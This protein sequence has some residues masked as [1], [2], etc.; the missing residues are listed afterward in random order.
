MAKDHNFRAHVKQ[1]LLHEWPRFFFIEFAIVTIVLLGQW[2]VRSGHPPKWM[3]DLD[4]FASLL[5]AIIIGGILHVLVGFG[6]ALASFVEKNFENY[7]KSMQNLKEELLVQRMMPTGLNNDSLNTLSNYLLNADKLYS[8][9]YVRPSL[10]LRLG[11][12]MNVFCLQAYYNRLRFDQGRQLAMVRFLVWEEEQFLSPA[13]IFVIRASLLVGARTKIITKTILAE[14]IKK[15][16]TSEQAK[17]VEC[18]LHAWLECKNIDGE[19]KPQSGRYG[20]VTEIGFSD[21][22]SM[23]KTSEAIESEANFFL[24]IQILEEFSMEVELYKAHMPDQIG[25]RNMKDNIFHA[26]SRLTSNRR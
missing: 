14:V 4:T 24:L 2:L 11:D 5:S 21:P 9:V 18:K 26:L 1:E 20:E 12:L 22:H 23:R 17:L 19:E 15:Y 3:V 8:I 25:E 16:G 7:D 6:F 13:G 10:W